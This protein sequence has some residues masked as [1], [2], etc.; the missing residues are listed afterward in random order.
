METLVLVLTLIATVVIG[1]IGLILQHQGNHH[2]RRQNEIMAKQEGVEMP[3][4]DR[5]PRWP[6]IL[7]ALMMFATWSVAGFDYYDRHVLSH[8]YNSDPDY[9]GKAPSKHMWR[10]EL[11]VLDGYDYENCE[12]YNVTF[13][14]NGTTPIKFSHDTVSGESIT[15]ATENPAFINLVVFLKAA[16]LLIPQLRLGLPPG[17]YTT[18]PHE[19]I[20]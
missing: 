9:V 4:V 1:A 19:T 13:K 16:N 5:P 2:F 10:D 3:P 14:Y 11:V 18:V 12:F 15:I 6:L 17:E 7:S 20:R 8:T